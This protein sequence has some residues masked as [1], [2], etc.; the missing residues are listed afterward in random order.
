MW[1]TFTAVVIV[2]YLVL[3]ST[4]PNTMHFGST[5]V[6][7]NCVCYTCSIILNAELFVHDYDF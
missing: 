7:M 6:Q 3:M 4:S 5:V 1:T 2:L